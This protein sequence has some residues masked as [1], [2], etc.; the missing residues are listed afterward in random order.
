MAVSSQNGGLHGRVEERNGGTGPRQVG[1]RSREDCNRDRR[2]L[3]R[4]E[5]SHRLVWISAY[6]QR[7]E[8]LFSL[9]G[10]ASRIMKRPVVLRAN[11]VPY[12]DL[13]CGA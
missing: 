7:G 5:Q 3:R 10:V 1:K 4:L 8:A 9:D 13:P 11:P 6:R 2:A 12:V